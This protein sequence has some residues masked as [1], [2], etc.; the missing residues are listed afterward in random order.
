MNKYLMTMNFLLYCSVCSLCHPQM[1]NFKSEL[2]V[3]SLNMGVVGFSTTV[4]LFAQVHITHCK[5]RVFGFSADIG[6]ERNNLL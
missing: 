4:H 2:L 6:V 5:L 1:S 3:S